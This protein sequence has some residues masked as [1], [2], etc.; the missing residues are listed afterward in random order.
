MPE[1]IKNPII[2]PK[3]AKITTLIILEH[4]K[5]AA[6]LGPEATLRQV[7]LK[8]WVLGGRREIR[9]AI[10][11]CES[12]L[13]KHPNIEEVQQ[14]DPNLPIARI[15]PSNF[16]AISLDFAGPF[17]I[18]KCG[19]CKNQSKCKKCQTASEKST[20]KCRLQ[21]VW[22]CIFVC[23]SSRGVHL[24]LLQDRSSES[25]LLAIKRMANRRSMPQIIHSDNAQEI[26]MGKNH[27][28]ELYELLNTAETHTKLAN[29]FNITWYHSAERSPQHNGLVERIVQVVKRPLY[30]TLMGKLVTETEMYTILTDC[31]AASNMRPLSSTSENA[32]DQNLL[33]ITPSHLL[34]GKS[35]VP[36]PTDIES[37]EQRHVKTSLNAKERWKQRK[38]I[39]HHYWMLWKEE[40]LMQLRALSKHYF[41][42]RDLK[43]G[44]VVL[45][46]T[47]K[48]TKLDWPI[49]V[50]DEALKGRD[51][52]VRSVWIRLP[53]NAKHITDKGKAKTQH[54]RI[55]R[56]IEQVSLLEEALD[57]HLNKQTEN[58]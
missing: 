54:K 44:D 19:I 50:V 12:N 22:I 37:Y 30:K 33:P 20:E 24:E 34:I 15:T 16:N 40:Y 42:R 43:E 10:N 17:K 47:E 41:E 2:L 7:R 58:I 55:K 26:V 3:D 1:Q 36:L 27:I 18:K 5:M 28:K 13:C 6:H 23:H 51:G 53:I 48:L 8:Y 46:L 52:R 14:Q 38:N 49:G 45:L 9:K 4:H 56:G 29:R 31:E 21:K 32:D 11:S 25:F 39:S 35:L 57:E